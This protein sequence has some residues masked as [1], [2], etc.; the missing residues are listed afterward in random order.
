MGNPQKDEFR[1]RVYKYTLRLLK[2]FAKLPSNMI[3]YEIK[4]QGIRSG[5]STG[6]NYFEAEAAISRKDYKN[7][8]HIRMT[9]RTEA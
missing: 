3:I 4:K 7:F 8:F 9:R 2:F 5:M 6:A 1:L